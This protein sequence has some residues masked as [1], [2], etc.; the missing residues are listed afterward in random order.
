[1]NSCAGDI[2]TNSSSPHLLTSAK[3]PEKAEKLRDLVIAEVLA[4]TAD[5]IIFSG[6][7]DTSI[8]AAVVASHGR[9]LHGVMVSVAE[10]NGLD[11]PFARMMVDRLRLELDILRPSLRE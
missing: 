1:M 11:E 7:L 9:R 3:R 4:S 10:G 2:M 6:G 5:G 8:L